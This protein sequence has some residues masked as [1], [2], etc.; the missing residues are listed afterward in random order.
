[1]AGDEE[2]RA[3]VAKAVDDAGAARVL[4]AAAHAEVGDLGV[5]V[6]ALRRALNGFSVQTRGRFDAVDRRFDA[7]DR[8]MDRMAAKVDEGFAQTEARFAQTGMVLRTISER[9]DVLIERGSGTGG[10]E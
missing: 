3:Q 5:K 10:A 2:L 7:V 4:A 9:I 6:E 8:R 1:M